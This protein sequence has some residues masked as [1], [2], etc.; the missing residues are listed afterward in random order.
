MRWG[1]MPGLTRRPM[2]KYAENPTCT[3]YRAVNGKPATNLAKVIEMMGGIEK[4]IGA[5]DVVVI[6]PN[7]QWW[8]Q[9]R[10]I[11]PR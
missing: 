5:D 3:L 6:K 1:V 7:V 2:R 9:G 4:L 8:N 11:W 10:P